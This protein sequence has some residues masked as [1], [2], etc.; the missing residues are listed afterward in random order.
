MTELTL[1]KN[2]YRYPQKIMKW[3]IRDQLKHPV[4]W[5]YSVTYVLL[6]SQILFVKTVGPVRS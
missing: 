5:G 1:F 6:V 2:L 4:F 3:H